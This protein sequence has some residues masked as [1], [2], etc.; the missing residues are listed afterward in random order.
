[1]SNNSGSLVTKAVGYLIVAF[2]A[3]FVFKM[4][5]GAVLGLFQFL[6]AIALIVLVGYAVIWAVRRL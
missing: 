2:V 6:M 3:L 1:M 4:V 5:L